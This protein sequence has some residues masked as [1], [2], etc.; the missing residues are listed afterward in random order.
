M[1]GRKERLKKGALEDWGSSSAR[2]AEPTGAEMRVAA[3]ALCAT[4][5]TRCSGL[6]AGAE[7]LLRPMRPAP[8]TTSLGDGDSVLREKVFTMRE[9]GEM[10]E[11]A[12]KHGLRRRVCQ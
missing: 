1:S 6:S 2:C 9:T 4:P 5:L 8:A 10:P 7:F 11:W 12:M 3:R